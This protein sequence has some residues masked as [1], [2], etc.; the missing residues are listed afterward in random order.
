MKRVAVILVVALAA[1]LAVG[2]WSLRS[3]ANAVS[4][5]RA[6]HALIDQTGGD[7]EVRCRT[8]NSSPFIVYLA[9]RAIAGPATLRVTFQDGD[10]VDY[11][12]AENQVVSLQQAA[13]DTN[14]VDDL[15]RVTKA[16]GAGS[17]VGWMSASRAPGTGTRVACSTL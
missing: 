4:G 16:T 13:G 14:G 12:L 10:F 1:G 7:V 9:V 11:P 5:K 3:T 8:T 6:D 15:I 2:I 17:I